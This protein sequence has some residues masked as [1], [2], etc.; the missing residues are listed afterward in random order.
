[1]ISGDLM[2][3]SKEDILKAEDLTTEEVDVPEWGGSVLV[4]G[5]TGRE[6]DA[7]E[8][9][10]RDERTGQRRPDALANIR[11][12]IVARCVVDDEGV[13]LFADAD[14][15]ALGEK[16]AAA[17]DRLFDVASRLSGMSDDDQEKM[18]RDFAL[19]DGDGSPTPLPPGLAKRSKNS[20]AR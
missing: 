3:L 4:R 19:A 12:K 9:S 5:M 11:S 16:S 17:T 6:R 20:S 15:A 18:T 8:V 10:M 14:I 7:L 1:M 13:R 2:R